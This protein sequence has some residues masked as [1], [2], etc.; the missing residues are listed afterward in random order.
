MIIEQTHGESFDFSSNYIGGA[1]GLRILI[2]SN[3]RI[4]QI[5][6]AIFYIFRQIQKSKT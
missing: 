3:F 5:Q 2:F 1:Q 4:I 6:Q